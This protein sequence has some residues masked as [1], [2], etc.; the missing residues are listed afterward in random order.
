LPIAAGSL[1]C[2]IDSLS[3]PDGMGQPLVTIVSPCYNQERYIA[4]CAESAL[5]QTYPSWEQVFV[6]DGS[7]DETCRILDSFR[8]SR[9]RVVRRP[10]RGL[11]ALAEAYNV[12]LAESRGSLVAILE[13]DDR[14]PPDKLAVQV[15]VFDDPSVILSWGHAGLIGDAGEQLSPRAFARSSRAPARVSTRAAF[16]RLTRTNFLIPS[17]TVMVRRA[18]LDS[19]GGFRQSG[20]GLFVDL[21]TWLWLTAVH[22]GHVT[23]VNEV[24]GIYRVHQAQTSQRKRLEMAA[25]HSS[26][27]QA[28]VAELDKTTLSRIGWDGSSKRRAETRAYLSRGEA[29]LTL[30]EYR[31]AYEEFRAGLS[32]A[33]DATDRVFALAGLASAGTR[34]N[35]VKAAFALRERARRWL[36]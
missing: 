24:L 2:A 10:H 23:F 1:W 28:V 18:A 7:T 17:V 31:A 4:A 33:S 30:G 8:D 29:F 34:V 27:V 36:G 3:D 11:G 35:L 12:A 25:E 9:F 20:S 22:E 26:V 5:A 15:P 32:H 13:G 6:D 16:R 14:W 19:I 21:P